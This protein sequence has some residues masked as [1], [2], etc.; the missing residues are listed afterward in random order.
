MEISLIFG[1]CTQHPRVSHILSDIL[2]LLDVPSQHSILQ[3]PSLELLLHMTTVTVKYFFAS[4]LEQ[5]AYL[6]AQY[7]YRA[8]V[9]LNKFCVHVGAARTLAVRE[10]LE[11]ALFKPQSV[12]F[13][14]KFV[15]N[16][17]D[18]VELLLYQNLKQGTSTLLQRD[19]SI[20]H[21]GN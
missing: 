7:N 16:K 3:P 19:S 14:A 1:D 12:L 17:T 18:N 20:F 21:A 11:H 9:L 13:G 6:R 10:L 4:C 15:P 8:C 5:N 2:V